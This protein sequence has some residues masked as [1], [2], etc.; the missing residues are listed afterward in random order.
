MEEGGQ[1][2]V[3]Q[4]KFSLFRVRGWMKRKQKPPKLLVFSRER[5]RTEARSPAWLAIFSVF[6]NSLP[7]FIVAA[8]ANAAVEICGRL[9]GQ[10]WLPSLLSVSLKICFG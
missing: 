4:R 5:T 8:H 6:Q 7:L 1:K 10:G 9:L 2:I 3:R